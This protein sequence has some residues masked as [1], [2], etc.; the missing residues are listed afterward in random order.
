MRPIVV[1][2]IALAALLTLVSCHK[3]PPAAVPST[4]PA[5]PTYHM[6]DGLQITPLDVDRNE[7]A[8]ILSIQ[9]WQFHVVCPSPETAIHYVLELRKKGQ[10][11]KEIL[12]STTWVMDIADCQMVAALYPLDGD[13]HTADKLKTRIR[14]GGAAGST[15]GDNPMKGLGGLSRDPTAKR[16]DDESFLLGE[17]SQGGT[18]PNP[19]NV[20]LFLTIKAAKHENDQR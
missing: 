2:S 17:F 6:S 13:I 4:P 1:R 8:D 19:D 9:M 20:R 5:N 11:L 3:Q 10:P 16:Q 15:I 7:I 18:V 12:N 14:I